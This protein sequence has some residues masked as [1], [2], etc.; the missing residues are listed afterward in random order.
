MP[1]T[2]VNHPIGIPFI[3][4]ESIDSTN[5]YALAQ[6]H[7]N[8]A[9]PGTCYFAHNQTA[10][11]GQRGK[12]WISEKEANIIL[13]IALK[14]EFLQAFQQFHLSAC[15]AVATHF[16]LSSYTDYNLKIKWPNDLYWKDR[17]LGG[18]L[19]ENIVG[20][21]S[22]IDLGPDGID[23]SSAWKWAIIG[24]GIN[25]NQAEFPDAL[26]NPVSIKQI[27]GKNYQSAGLAK[28]LCKTIEDSYNKL[29]TDGPGSTMEYYNQA[30]YKKDEVV[31]FKKD[32]RSF[33]AK[34][35]SVSQTGQLIV[36]HAIEEQFDFGEVEWVIS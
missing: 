35:K 33:E 30:L 15:V 21:L 23:A 14:P 5:N 24:I 11:K 31:K 4:L 36:Q 7:A 27:T 32:A 12:S 9:Q 1:L 18:I 13:S 6:I 29:I 34:V 8:L 2:S 25:N 20:G 22:G 17:K 26:K 3:E 10:G 19:I 16:F 28:E